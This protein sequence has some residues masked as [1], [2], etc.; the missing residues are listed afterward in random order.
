MPT[1]ERI[2]NVVAWG[3]VV[4]A[5]GLIAAMVVT[6]D[7]ERP[8][9][10][11]QP[12][13]SK[14]R[15]DT[16]MRRLPALPGPE[17]GGA[18]KAVAAADD[19]LRAYNQR[20]IVPLRAMACQLTTVSGHLF[21]SFSDTVRFSRDGKPRVIGF[22]VEVPFRVSEDGQHRHGA[23]RLRWDGNRWCFVTAVSKSD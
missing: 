18:P 16:S 22:T 6:G 8:R 5:V 1:S 15:S 4:A 21:D 10:T 9:N 12:Q 17:P 19:I 14:F 7:D 2:A 23:M 20:N 13:A 3:T 11:G